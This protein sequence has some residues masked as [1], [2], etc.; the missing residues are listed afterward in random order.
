MCDSVRRCNSIE[1]TDTWNEPTYEWIVIVCMLCMKIYSN[2]NKQQHKR[3][4]C[5]QTQTH[6]RTKTKRAEVDFGHENSVKWE[7]E[8]TT[9]IIIW[10]GDSVEIL[11]F[12]DSLWVSLSWPGV[13]LC[14]GFSLFLRLFF[15]CFDCIVFDQKKCKYLFVFKR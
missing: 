3:Y 1:Y 9:T 2:S 6:T 10:L 8:R 14:S 7:R 15:M 13:Q 4:K 5:I 12:S 11:A